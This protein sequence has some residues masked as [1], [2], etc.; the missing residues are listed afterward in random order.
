MRCERCEIEVSDH[1]E[2]C[3]ICEAPLSRAASPDVDDCTSVARHVVGRIR[4]ATVEEV[5]CE[6]DLFRADAVLALAGAVPADLARPEAETA[7]L[8]DGVRPVARIRKKRGVSSAEL[9]NALRS[10]HERGLLRLVG[11]VEEA[12]RAAAVDHGDEDATRRILDSEMMISARAMA[13]IKAM[14]DEDKSMFDGDDTESI[15]IETTP[16]AVP[17]PGDE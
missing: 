17:F 7:R 6:A 10:L 3:P 8:I 15:D 16:E 12:G 13:E 4:R 2:L 9:R 14:M 1:L 5:A 11:I